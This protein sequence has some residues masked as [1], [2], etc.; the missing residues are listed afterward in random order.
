MGRGYSG[1]LHRTNPTLALIKFLSVGQASG[2]LALSQSMTLTPAL[3][4]A[5]DGVGVLAAAARPVEAVME[6]LGD[7]HT[8]LGWR[9][10]E[11]AGEQR[12]H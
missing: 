4:L 8:G 10:A 6:V 7:L 3:Q 12:R 2:G 1:H 5:V 11:Q 9:V